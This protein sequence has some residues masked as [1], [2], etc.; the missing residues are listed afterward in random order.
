MEKRSAPESTP[1]PPAEP[2]LPDSALLV[3]DEAAGSDGIDGDAEAVVSASDGEG[4]PRED[5]IPKAVAREKQ[6]EEE[7]LTKHTPEVRTAIYREMAEQ[8]KEK[9]DRRRA[10]LPK[11]RDFEKEQVR[12]EQGKRRPW[13]G[14]RLRSIRA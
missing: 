10:N 9:E 14:C 11:E 7:E 8:K 1:G 12:M 2:A 4:S 6:G 3:K 5:N 13:C